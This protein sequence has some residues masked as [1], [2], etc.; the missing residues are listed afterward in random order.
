[1]FELRSVAGLSLLRRRQVASLPD[2]SGVG[3]VTMMGNAWCRW[4]G[5]VF[6]GEPSH[7]YAGDTRL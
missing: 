5:S 3:G 4:D 2:Y 1:L 7:P 6:V